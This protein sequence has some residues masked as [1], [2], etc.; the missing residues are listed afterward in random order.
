MVPEPVVDGTPLLVLGAV[1][2]VFGVMV[3]DFGTGFVAGTFSFVH[4]IDL[5]TE[6]PNSLT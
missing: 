3:A 5:S 4:C 6:Q 1:V 2:V